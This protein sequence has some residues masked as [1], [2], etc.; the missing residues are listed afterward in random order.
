MIPAKAEGL[1]TTAIL[2][3]G[4]FGRALS[5]LLL[6]AGHEVRAFDP[7]VQ[8]PPSMRV[9]SLQGLVHGAGKVVLALP[10]AEIAERHARAAPASRPSH[11]LVDVASVKHGPVRTLTEILG[12]EV[13]WVATHP[14]FGP[15]SIALGERPLVTVVCPNPL[16]PEAAAEARSF[17][18]S[19]GSEVI[20][21]DPA[22]HDRAMASTHALAFFV[23]KGLIDVRAG[24]GAAFVPPSFRALAR[25]IEAV[26]SDAGHLFA[27]IQNDNPFAAE[28]RA[29]LLSALEAI[30]RDLL[31][32]RGGSPASPRFSIPPLEAHAPDL[33]E[34]R[35]LIDDLDR[36]FIRLLARRAHLA[37]RAGRAKASLGQAVVDPER[38][39][40][41]VDARK[42]WA[43]SE[44]LDPDR[45]AEIFESLMRFSRAVQNDREH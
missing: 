38:E 26:R 15:T 33:C 39:R 41:V 23:A 11:L 35:E 30:D 34:T 5:E 45:V 17:F 3:F 13:P 40:E 29:R 21:Q 37:R 42:R 9:D 14:L 16:H 8:V 7:L 25:T 1:Q 32:P 43:R 28:S 27:T 2:G 22:A 6:D 12:R 44:G 10:I 20:E 31:T 18:I 19:L 36:D 24:E 4:R